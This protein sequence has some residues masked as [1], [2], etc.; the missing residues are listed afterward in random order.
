M[1]ALSLCCVPLFFEFERITAGWRAEGILRLGCAAVLF[2]WDL[3]RNYSRTA[4]VGGK[5]PAQR[6]GFHGISLHGA[7]LFGL[8]I[9]RL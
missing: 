1:S 2:K 4:A 9:S 7:N 3:Q 5:R 6:N 8:F